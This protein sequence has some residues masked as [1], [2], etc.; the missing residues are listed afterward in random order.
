MYGVM[1]QWLSG[2]CFCASKS[3]CCTV[4]IRMRDRVD[5]NSRGPNT[6]WMCTCSNPNNNVSVRKGVGVPTF[7][8]RRCYASSARHHVVCL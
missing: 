4:L 1:I 6:S 3:I 2:P 5:G 8:R 7:D